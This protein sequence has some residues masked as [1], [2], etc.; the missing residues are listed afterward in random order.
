MRNTWLFNKLFKKQTGNLKSGRF[1]S[2][3]L[4]R[5]AASASLPAVVAG[6]PVSEARIPGT[7]LRR[8]CSLQPPSPVSAGP[9]RDALSAVTSSSLLLCPSVL[10]P[11]PPAGPSPLKR[12]AFPA[13][14]LERSSPETSVWMFFSLPAASSPGSRATGS[15]SPGHHGA[16]LCPGACSPGSSQVQVRRSRVLRGPGASGCPSR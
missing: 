15:R 2:L 6:G 14:C 4:G 7:S 12:P 9:G 1:L 5:A 13:T 8:P 16:T 10:A 11:A 3:L